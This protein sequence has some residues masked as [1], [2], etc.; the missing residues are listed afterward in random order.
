MAKLQDAMFPGLGSLQDLMEAD[1]PDAQNQHM[2]ESQRALLDQTIDR[3]KTSKEDTRASLAN[4]ISGSEN[5][6]SPYDVK[7][8]GA[9]T[10]AYR[11]GLSSKLGM[12][13]ASQAATPYLE[14][15][16][17]MGS[18]LNMEMHRQDIERQ[19]LERRRAAE[20]AHEEARAMVIGSLIGLGGSAGARYAG[21]RSSAPREQAPQSY[22]DNDAGGGSG[23]YVNGGSG[24]GSQ[25]T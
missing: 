21:G 10:N 7:A 22:A 1:L 12:L 9:M 25:Y 23:Y 11:R 6:F 19:N 5:T 15:S 20:A 8:S 17:Q 16:K 13:K 18:A 2:G 4:A 3:A 14:S 24:R